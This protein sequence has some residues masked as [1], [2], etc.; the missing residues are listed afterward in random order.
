M[1]KKKSVG[2]SSILGLKAEMLKAAADS[3]KLTDNPAAPT[4]KKLKVNSNS[5]F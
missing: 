5:V 2:S 3:K 1:K 4:V